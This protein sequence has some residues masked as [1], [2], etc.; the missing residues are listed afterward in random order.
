MDPASLRQ[1]VRELVDANVLNWPTGQKM[2][3]R[4][5]TGAVCAVC[6]EQIGATDMEYGF[7]D[8]DEKY[9]HRECFIAWLAELEA[10]HGRGWAP[11]PEI[12]PESS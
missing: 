2:I 6:A 10:R 1:R 4:S 11:A 12:G 8:G 3:V 5:G 9:V 7:I